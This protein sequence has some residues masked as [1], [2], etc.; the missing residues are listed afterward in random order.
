MHFVNQC[1]LGKRTKVQ[2]IKH[3]IFIAMAKEDD[4][5]QGTFIFTSIKTIYNLMNGFK[6]K[7]MYIQNC[8]VF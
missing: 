6:S 7:H 8:M 3:I 1:I 4:I 5:L 2:N